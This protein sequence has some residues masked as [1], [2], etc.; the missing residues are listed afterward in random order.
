M[1]MEISNTWRRNELKVKLESL[2]D[3]GYQE[4]VWVEGIMPHGVVHDD[5]DLAVH[6]I[7]D[8]TDLADDIQSCIGEFLFNQYEVDCVALVVKSIDVVFDRYGINRSDGFYIKTPE[9]DDVVF[10]AGKALSKL[11]ELDE[12]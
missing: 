1:S 9:W 12:K 4:R 7:F 2:S 11:N 5:F 3:R 8:D 10:Y 6:F